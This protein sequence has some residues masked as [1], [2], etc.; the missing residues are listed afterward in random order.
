MQVGKI[1]SGGLETQRLR[2]ARGILTHAHSMV[3]ERPTLSPYRYQIRHIPFPV[4]PESPEIV[5]TLP[6]SFTLHIQSLTKPWDVLVKLHPAL[7]SL[8]ISSARRSRK[9]NNRYSA[10][11]P[12]SLSNHASGLS[13]TKEHPLLLGPHQEVMVAIRTAFLCPSLVPSFKIVFILN[14]FLP[15]RNNLFLPPLF[16]CSFFFFLTSPPFLWA[17]VW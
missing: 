7:V 10:T 14:T 4:P 15:S 6:F 1:L 3:R 12:S 9:F 16:S 5:Y 2:C 11:V 17:R 13:I 8:D